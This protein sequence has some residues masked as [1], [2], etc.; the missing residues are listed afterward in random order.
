MQ[1][2][3]ILKLKG[4]VCHLVHPLFRATQTADVVAMAKVGTCN[5][6]FV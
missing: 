4:I 2:F 1:T 3:M 5:E 6:Y